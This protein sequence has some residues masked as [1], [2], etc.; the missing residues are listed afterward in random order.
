MWIFFAWFSRDRCQSDGEQRAALR[1]LQEYQTPLIPEGWSHHRVEGDGWGVHLAHA[2]LN[3]WRWPLFHETEHSAAVSLGVPIGAPGGSTPHTMA[4][5]LLQGQEIHTE[6]VPPFALLALDRRS[7]RFALQQDWL[8]MARVFEYSSQG[9]V[10]LSNRPTLLP[11]FFGDPVRPDETGWSHYV[12]SGHFGGTSSPVHGVRLLAP[13]ERLTGAKRPNG[14][15]NLTHHQ[16]TSLDDFV[17]EGV[18][19][20]GG[21]HAVLDEAAD[22]FT[23]VAASAAALRDGPVALGLSGG[24]DSRLIAAALIAAGV[25]PKF[26]TNIDHPTEGDVARSLTDLL[27]KHRGIE[28]EHRFVRVAESRTVHTESLP[29]RVLRLQ[30]YYDHQF[31]SSYLERGARPSQLTKKQGEPVFSG[32]GGEIATAY[33]Y[34]KTLD[35]TP[36]AARMEP[37]V[38]KCLSKE[39]PAEVQS[40]LV[41]ERQRELGAHITRKAAALGVKGYQILDYA[42]MMER[43]RR[44]CTSAY[45][46][47]L[48]TP[49]T[50]REFVQAAFAMRATDHHDRRIHMDLLK[51]LVPEWADVPFVSGPSSRSTAARIW[52]GDGVPEIRKML[53]HAG[54]PLTRLMEADALRAVVQR[55]EEG[56]PKPADAAPL[57]QFAALAVAE[58]A[59]RP[60]TP[61]SATTPPAP[62]SATTPPASASAAS[63]S[64]PASPSAAT[65]SPS[66]RAR[67][68]VPRRRGTS[69]AAAPERG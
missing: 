7:P 36:T 6:V 33:W 13:G 23:R 30:S 47:G 12:A 51:R 56:C 17:A 34:P 40:P 58:S 60:P 44:W 43:M 57:R 41:G 2:E 67:L 65:S 42:Y 26:S 61:T 38:T 64:T 18:G 59:L 37:L 15:W 31:P 16:R 19:R 48:I 46:V 28:V 8:G 21:E 55:C 63:P 20:Q 69:D 4:G 11:A 27:M 32:A 9:V 25:L 53:D 62:A 24:K 10:A 22:G 1:R 68:R 50:T 5:R 66:W 49:F 39:V 29:H 45:S 3:G 14:T 35:G 52:D 54:G